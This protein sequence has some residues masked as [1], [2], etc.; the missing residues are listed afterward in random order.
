[1]AHATAT[2]KDL[3]KKARCPEDYVLD[4]EDSES[5]IVAVAE[6]IEAANRAAI[7]SVRGDDNR[8]GT[9]RNTDLDELRAALARVKGGAA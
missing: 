6:L 1:M 4:I 3:N 5:A 2:F 8:P 9:I 7:A